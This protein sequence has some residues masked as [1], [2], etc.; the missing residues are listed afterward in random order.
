[1]SEIGAN[2]YAIS[3]SVEP[4]QA[5]KNECPNINVVAIDLS[6]WDETR[7]ALT[8]LLKDKTIDGLVNNAGLA[9]C[10]PFGELTE[11]DFDESVASF[12]HLLFLHISMYFVFVK[13]A[14][15]LTST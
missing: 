6:K 11:K 9:I 1:M 2:V 3:R 15:P 4:L 10:K 8:K 14:A 12:V 7:S 5:L 13:F